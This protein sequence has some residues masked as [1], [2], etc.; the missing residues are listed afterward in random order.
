MQS[1]P[2]HTDDL[3]LSFLPLS[4]TF[5]RTVGYY[6]PVMAGATVAYARSIPQLAEDL[7][8]IRPTLLISVPRIYERVYAGIKAKLE[9]GSA[10]KRSLFNLTVK[11]GWSRFERAQGR[12]PWRASH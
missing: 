1:F 8:S 5:E 10:L 7:A 9:E 2:V 6:L 3:L 12:G 4:H 11:V